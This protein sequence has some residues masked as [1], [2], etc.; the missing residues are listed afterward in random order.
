MGRNRKPRSNKYNFE[1]ELRKVSKDVNKRKNA[2]VVAFVKNGEIQHPFKL[3]D[4][5]GSTFEIDDKTYSTKFYDSTNLKYAGL[6][7]LLLQDSDVMTS[8]GIY[9][10]QLVSGRS[11][12]DAPAKIMVESQTILRK[13]KEG[14]TIRETIKETTPY[15]KPV[16]PSYTLPPEVLKGMVFSMTKVDNLADFLKK[17]R[18]V[19][20]VMFGILGGLALILIFTYN[21]YSDQLPRVLSAVN[22]CGQVRTLLEE[23]AK[24]ITK[25]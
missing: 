14:K 7:M 10:N 21:M 4:T 11:D 1:K 17:N 6:P 9:Y 12:K 19:I 18:M 22:Q 24:N 15:L 3:V 23:T 20:Y 5:S 2:G 16:V 8:A 13:D 25:I